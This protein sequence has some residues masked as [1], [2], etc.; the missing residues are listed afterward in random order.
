M[1]KWCH[2]WTVMEKGG[3]SIEEE[4]KKWGNSHQNWH[5][6]CLVFSIDGSVPTEI[7]ERKR[8]MTM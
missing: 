2:V 4:R 3:S 7:N 1:K 6:N 5:P 8:E